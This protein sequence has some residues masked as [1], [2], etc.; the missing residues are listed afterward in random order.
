MPFRPSW[1]GDPCCGSQVMCYGSYGA[2]LVL[3]CIVPIFVCLLHVFQL[4]LSDTTI[5]GMSI[6]RVL[7]YPQ[8]NK[9]V[10]VKMRGPAMEVGDIGYASWYDSGYDSEVCF[11]AC[12]VGCLL[13]AVA[14]CE[15]HQKKCIPLHTQIS[16]TLVLTPSS[17]F[18]LLP[19]VIS[20]PSK[21]PNV[22]FCLMYDK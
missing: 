6:T 1:Y 14:R 8:L 18:L 4:Y 17:L 3:P 13:L 7:Y 11:G 10:C 16:T 19:I 22:R 9:W 5:T 21:I 12:F 2:I 15:H 20:N